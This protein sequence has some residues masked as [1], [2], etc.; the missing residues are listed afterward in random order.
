MSDT[1]AV[2]MANLTMAEDQ[3]YSSV[4]EEILKE[5]FYVNCSDEDIRFAQPLLVPEASAPFLTP[6]ITTEEKFGQIP[7]VYISCLRDKAISPAIQE[8]MYTNLPCK[9]IFRMDT[10]HSPF[11]SAPEDLARHLLL[12]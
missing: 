4:K 7:R 8:K 2:V 1:E 6:V 5:A 10:D 12:I 3:S 9:K 11:F